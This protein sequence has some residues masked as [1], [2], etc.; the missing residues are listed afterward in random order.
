MDLPS[1]YAKG[2]LSPYTNIDNKI[3]MTLTS[4]DDVND[5][6]TLSIFTPDV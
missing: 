6:F 1:I 3:N 5:T 2:S 4:K